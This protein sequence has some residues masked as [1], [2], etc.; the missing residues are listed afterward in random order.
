MPCVVNA[1]FHNPLNLRAMSIATAILSAKL[2]PEGALRFVRKG[3]EGR[4]AAAQR[5]NPR[6]ARSALAPDAPK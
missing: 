3:L 2:S 4:E 6:K 1:T 5:R